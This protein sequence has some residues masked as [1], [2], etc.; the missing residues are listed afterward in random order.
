MYDRKGKEMRQVFFQIHST[1]ELPQM[2]KDSSQDKN[3]D[4]ITLEAGNEYFVEVTP[5]GQSVTDQ[6]KLID[7]KD[8][9]CLLSTEIFPTSKLKVQTKQNCMYECK[10]YYAIGHC[11]CIPWDFPLNISDPVEECDVFGRTC[12]YNAIKHGLLQLQ[13]NTLHFLNVQ[14]I[15]A[16]RDFTIRDPLH[17]ST[18]FHAL[19]L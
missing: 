2:I 19:N 11:G 1:N 16:F 6:F 4:S 18:Q 15:P 7:Q 8:R 9:N 17:F 5:F 12:Y 3:M 13:S 14:G 10:V